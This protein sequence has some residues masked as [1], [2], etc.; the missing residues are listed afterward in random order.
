MSNTSSTQIENY[1]LVASATLMWFDF[2][3]TLPAEIQ[4]IW[5]RKISGA[6]LAYIG[7]RY[8]LLLERIVILLEVLWASSDQMCGVIL[9][10]DDTLY[11]VNYFA[12][13]ALTTLR[14]YAVCALN[15]TALIVVLALSIVNPLVL[16]VESTM[17][18]PAQLPQMSTGC[19][20]NYKF[21]REVLIKLR[22]A[23]LGASI[24]ANSIVILLTWWKTMN[25]VR[26]SL[27][28]SVQL[29][30]VQILIRNGTLY[31]L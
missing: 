31:F 27:Q 6:S 20:Y 7:I 14:V 9:H 16:V 18:V 25:A 4:G 8:T 12:V 22:N 29:P 17:Y 11:I 2:V 10:V 5:R 3:L 19:Q 13:A 26:A 30:V 1:C 21:S 28:S 15:R 23:S 24:A